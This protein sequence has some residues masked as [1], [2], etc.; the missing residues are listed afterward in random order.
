MKTIITLLFAAF[1]A[2]SVNAQTSKE[3]ARRVVLGGKTTE[4]RTENP[5][6]VILGGGN[7]TSTE[8]RQAEI[9]RINRSYDE[10]IH[11]IRNNPSL[12]QEE[13]QRAIAQLERERKNKIRSVN[14]QYSGKN[15]GDKKDKEGK[16]DKKR[17]KAKANNGKHLGWEKGVGNPHKNG[18]KTKAKKKD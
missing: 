5:R 18:G 11:A 9:E 7:G 2:G 15:K 8:S 12:S 4:T 14:D 13:K 3:E 10:R 16:K 17:K 6:D 1:A